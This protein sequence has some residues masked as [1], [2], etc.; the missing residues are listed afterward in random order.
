MSR[1][2]LSPWESV[3][4]AAALD[5]TAGFA[6]GER[7]VS[8]KRN[9]DAIVNGGNARTVTVKSATRRNGNGDG[10]LRNLL[11]AKPP[12]LTGSR[13]TPARNLANSQKQTCCTLQ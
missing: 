5:G 11:P 3:T 12:F 4:V 8:T 7:L 6:V 1:F 9:C 2:V 10:A 13:K